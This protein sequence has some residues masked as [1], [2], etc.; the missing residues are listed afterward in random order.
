MFVCL[1]IVLC[2]FALWFACFGLLCYVCLICSWWF[3]LCLGVVVL[4]FVLF[5]LGAL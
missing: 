5:A 2:A 3:T 4:A 1:L